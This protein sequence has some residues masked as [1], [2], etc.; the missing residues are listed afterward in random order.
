MTCLESTLESTITGVSEGSEK[1][2]GAETCRAAL[3]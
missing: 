3:S 2:S 1:L